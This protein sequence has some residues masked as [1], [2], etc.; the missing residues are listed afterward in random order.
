MRK[1]VI[2]YNVKWEKVC[3]GIIVFLQMIGHAFG[4]E[5]FIAELIRHRAKG[6]VLQF[7]YVDILYNSFG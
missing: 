5:K 2:Y 1:I 6:T 3:C 7:K 4:V